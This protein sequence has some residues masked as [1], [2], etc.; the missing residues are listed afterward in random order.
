MEAILPNL[1]MMDQSRVSASC[2][3][4]YE[5]IF[6]RDPLINLLFSNTYLYPFFKLFSISVI[7]SAERFDNFDAHC[8]G[9]YL[10]LDFQ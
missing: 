6:E 1:L 9:E 5:T 10:P 8:R 7:S 3:F 4:L 2:I